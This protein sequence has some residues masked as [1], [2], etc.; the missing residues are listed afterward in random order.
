MKVTA[1]G[2]ADKIAPKV[3]ESLK[4]SERELIKSLHPW[5]LRQAAECA[6]PMFLNQIPELT[7]ITIDLVSTEFGAMN[8]NDLLSFLNDHIKSKAGL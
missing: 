3:Q 8:V 5:F 7:R 2:L 6:Y 4:R 1:A